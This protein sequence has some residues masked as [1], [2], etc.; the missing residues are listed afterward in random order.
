MKYFNAIRLF[1]SIV[2]R[3]FHGAKIGIKEA[4]KVSSDIWLNP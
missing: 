4:W 2:G 1:L 3:D